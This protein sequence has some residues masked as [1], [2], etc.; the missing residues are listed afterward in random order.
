MPKCEYLILKQVNIRKKISGKV[1]STD[2]HSF[3]ILHIFEIKSEYNNTFSIL[4][5]N[6]TNSSVIHY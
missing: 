4:S 1:I 3:L 2:K 5:V 6:T